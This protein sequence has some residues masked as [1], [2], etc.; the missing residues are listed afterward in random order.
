MRHED[1]PGVTGPPAVA[2]RGVR[3]CGCNAALHPIVTPDCERQGLFA[4]LTLAERATSFKKC[5]CCGPDIEY[6]RTTAP[7]HLTQ[8]CFVV[9]SWIGFGEHQALLDSVPF[10]SLWE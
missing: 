4:A 3:D 8:A 9:S 10:L 1:L 5:S 2:G 7:F 6:P